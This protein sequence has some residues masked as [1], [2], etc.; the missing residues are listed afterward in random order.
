VIIVDKALRRRTEEG[1]PIRVGMVGAG[2]MG[3]PIARRLIQEIE[4]IDLVGIANRN[5]ENAAEALRQA[6]VDDA[7]RVDTVAGLEAAIAEGRPAYTADP[8][9]L[10]AAD[11]VDLVLEVTG[12][13]DFGAQVVLDAIEHGKH[14]LLMNAELDGTVGPLLN[15]KATEAGVRYGNVDG[16]QPGVIMN[17]YRFVLGTG[18]TPKLLG[19]IKGL[20]DPYRTPT[21]QQAFAERWGQKA[22]M[23]TSFAD[24]TKVNFE[25]AICANATGFTVAQRGMYGPEVA[26]GSPIEEIAAHYP[27]DDVVAGNGIVDY[28]VGASPGPGVFVLATNDDPV[29][30]HYL[31]LYKLGEGPLYCFYTPYHLCHFEVPSSIVRV[32]DFDDPP[33]VPLGGPV[34]EVVAIA[35]T[36]LSAGQVLDGLGEYLTYGECENHGTA[37]AEGL[38]PIAMAEG[39][40]LR[41]DVPK[42]AALTFDDVELAPRLINDL[43]DEQVKLFS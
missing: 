40:R 16:D 9:V 5:P 29:H 18:C 3:R 32:M 14:T 8:A 42:D 35:K 2:F 26:P 31:D 38:L 4:G 37:R 1:R 19:N 33:V 11:G 15:A 28:C 17:L 36:D 20:Q 21:T 27:V 41:H 13:I 25:M 30:Q 24:G 6:G 22:H 12:A 7:P 34:V 10:C 43:F 39:A 23:V